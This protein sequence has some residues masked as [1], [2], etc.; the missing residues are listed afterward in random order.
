[1]TRPPDPVLFRPTAAYEIREALRLYEGRLRGSG[2]SLSPDAREIVQLAERSL[3]VWSSQ[4]SAQSPVSAHNDLVPTLLL[5]SDVVAQLNV[6]DSTVRRAVSSGELASVRIGRSLR[7]RPA[8]V[9][10][11]IDSL[12]VDGGADKEVA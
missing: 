10:K 4:P 3:A 8:D 5:L 7:F 9:Q 6:S 11:Y 12:P 2:R 1:M